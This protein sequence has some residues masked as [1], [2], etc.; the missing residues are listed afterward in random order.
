MKTEQSLDSSQKSKL[1]QSS[2][3][4][5]SNSEFDEDREVSKFKDIF[6][7]MNMNGGSVN[8]TFSE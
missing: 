3:S 2:S 8:E 5:D 4:E 6:H 7:N 1:S